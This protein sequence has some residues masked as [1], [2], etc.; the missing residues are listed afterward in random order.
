MTELRKTHL[1]ERAVERMAEL[2]AAGDQGG[3][4]AGTR[5]QPQ[6]RPR[7]AAAEPPQAPASPA[8]DADAPTA[9]DEV[10]LDALA[11]AGLV[12]A[13]SRRSQ[14]AEE[15]NVTAGR[16]FR[17]LR[18][19]SGRGIA[20]APAN[21]L[22]V[23]SAKPNE[24]KSFAAM[25]LA[26]SLALGKLSDALLIDLDSKAGGLT[27]KLGL[28]E[29]P[30]LFDLATEPGHRPEALVVGTAVRGLTILPIGRAAAGGPGSAQRA[31]T[32]PVITVIEQVARRFSNRVVILDCTPCLST[33]DASTLAGSVGQIAMI[34]EAER[35]Q[36][37]DLEASLELLRPC[38]NISLIL[39]KTRLAAA[40]AFG[41]DSYYN[42]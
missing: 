29:R 12:V 15:W 10:G 5:P 22:L 34:V 2:G 35:T 32:R 36:R 6:A 9:L 16:L 39:N 42:G 27:Q 24:G 3:F 20:E 31:I 14:I 21:L 18:T 7:P 13:G 11:S 19:I 26:G 23:T 28:S 17:T 4:P 41:G 8:H 30:G 40:Q 25:N 33:S 37:D 38:A 1:V